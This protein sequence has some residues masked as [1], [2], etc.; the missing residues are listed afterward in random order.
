MAWDGPKWGREGIFPI[1]PDLADILGDMGLDFENFNAFVF[2][3][4]IPKFQ[5]SRLTILDFKITYFR[6]FP[7]SGF[8]GFTNLGLIIVWKLNF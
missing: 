2:V 3:S 8:S 5:I 1:N 6:G 4:G 7:K